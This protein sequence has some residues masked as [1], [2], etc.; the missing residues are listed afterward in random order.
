MRIAI[1]AVGRAKSGPEAALYQEY[2]KRIK[3]PL[4]LTEVEERRRL[5]AAKLKAREAQLLLAATAKS[6]SIVALDASGK[7]IGSEAFA[8][9]MRAWADGGTADLAFLIGGAGGHGEAVLA[10]AA[11]VLSLGAMTWPHLMARAML[12]EQIY[13]AESIL[14]GHPY[15]RA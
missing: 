1:I 12:C 10:R 13:R 6:A 14:S 7:A 11:L 8:G 2:A 4:S 3:W 5:P 15:H 9:K